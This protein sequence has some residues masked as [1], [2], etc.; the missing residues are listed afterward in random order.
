MSIHRSIYRLSVAILFNKELLASFQT[1]S[2]T[3]L[4][5]ER[6]WVLS[7]TLLQR[8][9]QLFVF[10]TDMLAAALCVLYFIPDE[11]KMLFEKGWARAFLFYR[12]GNWGSSQFRELKQP[13]PH[14]K[15]EPAFPHLPS[16]CLFHL[17][18]DLCSPDSP[19]WAQ[20]GMS[21]LPQTHMKSPNWFLLVKA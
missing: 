10:C 1:A 12:W 7:H 19:K 14:G 2:F 20:L 17:L 8:W 16:L 4:K 13:K 9:Y 18:L 11:F 3:I 21:L 5:V 15:L 6:G